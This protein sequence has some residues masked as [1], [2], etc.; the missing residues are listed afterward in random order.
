MS[1][2]PEKGKAEVVV[3]EEAGERDLLSQILEEGRLARNDS[4]VEQAKDLI[5][6][7]VQQVMSGEMVVSRDLE[8][9]IN[10]RV[11]AIDKLL[12]AQL[13]EVMHHPDFQKLEASW[14]G[15]HHLVFESET[16]TMLKIR[17]L[18]V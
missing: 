12:S 3:R 5:G 2:N 16:G 10:A 7:F 6:A 15:L 13:N 4:Q 14:R 18:N 1:K 8:A 11:A 17:V 9:S